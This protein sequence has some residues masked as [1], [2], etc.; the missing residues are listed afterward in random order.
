MENVLD[1]QA[2][3]REN[4]WIITELSH[5]KRT[6]IIDQHTKSQLDRPKIVVVGP[7]LNF[8]VVGQL[9]R[10]ARTNPYKMFIF[11]APNLEM[12]LFSRYP[13]FKIDKRNHSQIWLV[14][15]ARPISLKLISH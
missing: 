7:F 2:G 3:R 12:L 15:P 14:G 4:G 8:W 13:I 11:K 1:G 9:G 10:S 5:H 6:C